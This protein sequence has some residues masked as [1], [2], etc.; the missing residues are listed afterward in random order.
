MNDDEGSTE[1]A[2]GNHVVPKGVAV[3]ELDGGKKKLAKECPTDLRLLLES[4]G[5]MMETY[6]KLVQAVVD[7]SKTRSVFGSWKDKEFESIVDL[8]REDFA[9][10]Q[11][12]VALCK[13]K[14]GSG[15]FRWLE[16]IDVT[17]ADGY[18]PQYDVANLSGSSYQNSVH[19]D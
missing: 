5:G 8:F 12:K 6:N 18:V 9:E 15:T 2:N 13:R 7:E 3:E 17:V 16:F 11:I 4:R 10:G 19:K 14:S 1:V